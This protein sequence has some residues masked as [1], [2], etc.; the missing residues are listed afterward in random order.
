MHCDE[1]WSCKALFPQGT[2][3]CEQ[4]IIQHDNWHNKDIYEVL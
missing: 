3:K 2:Q 1:F 4:I